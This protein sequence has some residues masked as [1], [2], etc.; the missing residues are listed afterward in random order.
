[1]VVYGFRALHA[2]MVRIYATVP[3]DYVRLEKSDWDILVTTSEFNTLLNSFP[4]EDII[5]I[6]P[7]K[8]FRY[9]V[10]TAKGNYDIHII[11]DIESSTVI[12]IPSS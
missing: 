3:S 11:R 1:M 4:E 2:R 9:F 7:I 8:G 6:R 5:S 12:A 10:K